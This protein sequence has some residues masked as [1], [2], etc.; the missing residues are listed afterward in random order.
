MQTLRDYRNANNANQENMQTLRD[1]SN[2]NNANQENMQMLRDYSNA[3]NANQENMQMLRD[4]CNA[5][6]ANQ[7]NMQMLRDYHNAN[8]ANQEN[9]RN[10]QIKRDVCHALRTKHLEMGFQVVCCATV[11]NIGLL[12]QVRVQY[13]LCPSTRHKLD[14]QCA[15]RV[16]WTVSSLQLIK[17]VHNSQV[18]CQGIITRNCIACA[19]RTITQHQTIQQSIIKSLV[20]ACLDLK[21]HQIPSVHHVL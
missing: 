19:A 20:H 11:E 17:Y 15:S 16:K 18:V 1:Y 4:Y 6:N 9:I 2:V 21:G 12:K 13:V 10:Q 7:E 14:P 8:N 3:N 5:N